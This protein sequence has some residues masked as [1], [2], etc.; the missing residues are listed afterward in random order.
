MDGFDP[1]IIGALSQNLRSLKETPSPFLKY[2]PAAVLS[3]H[4]LVVDVNCIGCKRAW[5]L[6]PLF[7]SP[8][9]RWDGPAASNEQYPK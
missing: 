5:E 3:W 6:P 8:G 4:V 7:P 9:S 1:L 2:T